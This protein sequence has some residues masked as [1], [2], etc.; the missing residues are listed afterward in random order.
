[1]LRIRNLPKVRKKIRHM[2]D[3]T[4]FC[5]ITEDKKMITTITNRFMDLAGVKFNT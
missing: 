3:D 2:L 4:T 1:M 5:D